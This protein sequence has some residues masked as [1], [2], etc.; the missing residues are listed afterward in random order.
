M[1]LMR[2]AWISSS[3]STK[4]TLVHDISYSDEKCDEAPIVA[5]QEDLDGEDS[6]E[7]GALHLVPEEASLD[8]SMQLHLLDEDIPTGIMD[9]KEDNG[10][11][12]Y[13]ELPFQISWDVD[14]WF[15]HGDPIYDTKSEILMEE[16]INLH[17]PFPISIGSH[18]MVHEE[19]I[20]DPISFDLGQPK[21]VEVCDASSIVDQHPYVLINGHFFAS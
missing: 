2:I 17:L 18:F 14:S 21:D 8:A 16:D 3:L 13:G 7:D 4:E 11:V 19:D 12:S 15:T 1:S 6:N 9:S 20:A 10:L 5:P